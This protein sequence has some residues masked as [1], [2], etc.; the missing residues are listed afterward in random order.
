MAGRAS[1]PRICMTPEQWKLKLGRKPEAYRVL[2]EKGT[3]EP[4][5][6]AYY[7]SKRPGIYLCDASLFAADS[8]F[9]SGCGWPA[10]T[11]PLDSSAVIEEPDT[12]HGMYR[13]E[14]KCSQCHGHLGH[15]FEDGPKEHGGL[16]YCINSAALDFKKYES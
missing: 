3:E 13:K 12:S 11:K 6:G 7:D 8:K 16:R 10:F 2:R 15:V 4:Y 14:I 9:D 5:H 1:L